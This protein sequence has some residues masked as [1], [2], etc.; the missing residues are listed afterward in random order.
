VEWCALNISQMFLGEET[1]APW[2]GT[3]HLYFARGTNIDGQPHFFPG[4]IDT[5]ATAR[6]TLIGADSLRLV[7]SGPFVDTLFAV[8]TGRSFS[9]TWDCDARLPMAEGRP[10]LRGGF[11]LEERT[12][13]D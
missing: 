9:G 5:S 1:V 6:L 10:I 8:R 4:T 13:V 12:P 11:Y 7:I 2:T 3:V